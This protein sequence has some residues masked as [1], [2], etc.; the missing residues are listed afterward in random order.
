[1]G[2]G[3]GGHGKPP[4]PQKKMSLFDFMICVAGCA[5]IF[6]SLAQLTEPMVSSQGKV[7]IVGE[8]YSPGWPELY[9]ILIIH[10]VTNFS[11]QET[12][13]LTSKKSLLIR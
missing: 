13:F 1:M 4:H 7:T 9:Y 5:S 12:L 10:N 6:V 8:A 11:E 2:A 3:A